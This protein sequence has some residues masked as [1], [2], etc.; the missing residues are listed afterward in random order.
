M[1][2]AVEDKVEASYSYNSTRVEGKAP[3][4]NHTVEFLGHYVSNPDSLLQHGPHSM[5]QSS[6]SLATQIL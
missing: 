3:C 4:C 5:L 2:A 6:L 1:R